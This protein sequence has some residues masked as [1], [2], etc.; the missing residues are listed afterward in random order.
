MILGIAIDLPEVTIELHREA[1][2]LRAK[3]RSTKEDRF[4]PITAIHYKKKVSKK[5]QMNRYK[6]IETVGWN[7]LENAW[8]HFLNIGE[9]YIEDRQ[10]ILETMAEFL[11]MWYGGSSQVS[12]AKHCIECAEPD[13]HPISSAP[14]LS[15][16][17][18]SE[19]KRTEMDKILHLHVIKPAQSRGASPIVFAQKKGGSLRVWNHYR[20]LN[21][22]IFND[23][24]PIPRMEKCPDSLGK[25]S[26]FFT[27]DADS[28]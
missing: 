24:Y 4:G 15:R 20:K 26:I 25:A 16:P 18:A 17:K 8:R 1:V 5:D 27:Q 10:E 12:M 19:F 6:L 21:A 22:L 11:H 23:Q 2:T 28:G 13:V 9:N 14:I 7:G 3:R